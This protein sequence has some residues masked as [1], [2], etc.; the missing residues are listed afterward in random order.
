MLG[1][2]FGAVEISWVRHGIEN[3]FFRQ[4]MEEDPVKPAAR[5]FENFSG[6]PGD[7]FTLPVGVG[8]Q[9]DLIHILGRVF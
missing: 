3:G 9:V 2:E 7:G 6:M 1:V 8:R 4:L 5:L